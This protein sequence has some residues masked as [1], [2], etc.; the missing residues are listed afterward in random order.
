M[1]AGPTAWEQVLERMEADVA[2]AAAST[3]AAASGTAP[4]GT[5]RA[6]VPPQGLGPLPAGLV[7]R[8]RRIRANQEQVAGVLGNSRRRAL[9]HLTAIQSVPQAARGSHSVFL[10]ITG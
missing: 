3:A 7:E 2:A 1:P 8:A 6:W 10:D 9:Q 4:D 5:W